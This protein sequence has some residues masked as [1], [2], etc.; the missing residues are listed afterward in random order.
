MPSVQES[1]LGRYAC[2]THEE[3]DQRSKALGQSGKM[4]D[5]PFDKMIETLQ[6]LF[7]GDVPVITKISH[8]EKSDPYLVLI[9]TLLSLRT[10]G[11]R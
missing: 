8:K 5:F 2:G 9:G 7:P 3:M 6:A 1:L 10:K 11:Q 4:M